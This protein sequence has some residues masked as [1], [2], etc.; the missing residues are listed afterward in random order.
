M[1][2]A[3]MNESG[4]MYH[5]DIFQTAA[6]AIGPDKIA[7]AIASQ[8]A[9]MTK[10]ATAGAEQPVSLPEN[11]Q[12]ISPRQA[13]AL[14][15]YPALIEFLGMPEGEEIAKEVAAKV[16]VMMV[17]KIGNNAKGLSKEAYSCVADN[18]NIKQYYVAEDE[19]WG[20]EIIAS[21]PFRGDEALYYDRANDKSYV[22]R[23]KGK[24]NVSSDFNIIHQSA[25]NENSKSEMPE[26]EN[27]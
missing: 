3:P 27:E 26:V 2:S 13:K 17:E 20:C 22:V 19:S 23:G 1:T 7:A 21:G 12:Y 15:S 4:S 11:L 10:F 14:A 18:Q 16:N 5:M 9:S 6:S 8:P 24:E 25:K